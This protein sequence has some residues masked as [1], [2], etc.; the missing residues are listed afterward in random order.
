MFPDL[1]FSVSAFAH[2]LCTIKKSEICRKYLILRGTL[3]V[4]AMIICTK[5]IFCGKHFLLHINPRRTFNYEFPTVSDYF[6][7]CK[8]EN[9]IIE[10]EMMEQDFYQTEKL[11]KNIFKRIQRIFIAHNNNH[12]QLD[13]KFSSYSN[14]L[15]RNAVRGFIKRQSL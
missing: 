15:L 1:E 7:A 11:S 12:F 10:L 2:L 3:C 8:Y 6:L 14:A 4:L 13:A 5:D 9:Q